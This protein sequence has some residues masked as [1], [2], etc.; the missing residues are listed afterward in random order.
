MPGVPA[1]EIRQYVANQIRKA[2]AQGLAV[3]LI[4][5]GDVA[6]AFSPRK[7]ETPAVCSAIQTRAFETQ[8]RATLLHASLFPYQGRTRELVF[9]IEP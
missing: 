9:R 2:R 5:I 4:R 6:D 8:A 3:I 7:V 1:D